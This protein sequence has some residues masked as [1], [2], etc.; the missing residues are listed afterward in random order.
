MIRECVNNQGN[1]AYKC[2]DMRPGVRVDGSLC[3]VHVIVKHLK[4]HGWILSSDESLTE[5]FD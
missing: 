5:T 2:E 4:P 3:I 1:E